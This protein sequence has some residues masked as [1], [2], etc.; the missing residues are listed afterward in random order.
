[1]NIIFDSPQVNVLKQ[2]HVVLELDSFLLPNCQTPLKSWCVVE[3]VPINEI[4]TVDHYAKLHSDLIEHFHKKN[5]NVCKDAVEL[6]L[7]RWGGELDSFYLHLKDRVQ[8]LSTQSLP[9]SWNG[10]IVKSLPITKISDHF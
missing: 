3:Q 1:M 9:E 2:R 6:L 10:V 5:W 8:T 4:S 7:G